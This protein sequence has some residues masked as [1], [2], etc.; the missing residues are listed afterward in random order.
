MRV[1]SAVS[2]EQAGLG[3]RPTRWQTRGIG[4]A[5][6]LL[7]RHDEAIPHL[8]RLAEVSPDFATGRLLLAANLVVLGRDEQ[9]REEVA[10]LLKAY[11][12]LTLKQVVAMTP[13]SREELLEK[14]LDELRRAGVPD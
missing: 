3:R 13:F 9:A 10:T 6:Y 4:R 2:V 7:G 5:Y 12:S 14:Y 1:V 11:P 8:N